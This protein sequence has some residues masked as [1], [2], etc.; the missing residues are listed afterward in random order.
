M[1][2]AIAALIL[3]PAHENSAAEIWDKTL[4][5]YK[6]VQSIRGTIEF[7][8]SGTAGDLHGQSVILT[9][10]AA[11]QPN[12]FTLRQTKRTGQAM[13]FAAA[14][15][16]KQMA[17]T[18]P[19]DWQSKSPNARVVFSLG[20]EKIE[21]ALD[22]FATLL[23]DRQLPVALALYNPEDVKLFSRAIRNPK[24]VKEFEERG[25]TVHHLEAEYAFSRFGPADPSKKSGVDAWIPIDLYVSEDGDLLGMQYRETLSFRDA[26]TG[27]N[28]TLEL[29][30]RWSVNLQVNAPLED[31]LFAIR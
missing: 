9:E 26:R 16:G 27:L 13:T 19:P 14:C 1:T 29:V 18:A 17:F 22:A 5:R 6:N 31:S 23:L 10:V 8:Q 25:T 2:A 24:F 30:N 28:I 12:K 20:P 7:V 3:T 4:A 21:G 11:K 15:D